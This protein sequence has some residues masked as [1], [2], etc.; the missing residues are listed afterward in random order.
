[1]I[2]VRGAKNTAYAEIAEMNEFAVCIMVW[3]QIPFDRIGV[4]R[5]HV[6]DLPR[7][8]GKPYQSDEERPSPNVQVLG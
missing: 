2:P 1:M 7:V 4:G 5:P 8:D 3:T 6:Q